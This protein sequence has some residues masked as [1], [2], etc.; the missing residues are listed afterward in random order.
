MCVHPFY[1]DAFALHLCLAEKLFSFTF[2][3]MRNHVVRG[4]ID[5]VGN[6]KEAKEVE[7]RFVS[8]VIA[9]AEGCSVN[10]LANAPTSSAHLTDATHQL[11]GRFVERW[12]ELCG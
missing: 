11:R 1:H 3:M 6:Q 7:R 9:L 5:S 8:M 12:G 2:Q 4:L 10:D